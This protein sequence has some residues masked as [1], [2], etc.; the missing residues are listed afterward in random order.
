MFDSTAAL[1]LI[2]AYVFTP[3]SHWENSLNR[4][5]IAGN[6]FTYAAAFMPVL[7]LAAEAP[8][9][10][11]FQTFSYAAASLSRL[12]ALAGI[13]LYS[14][15]IILSSRN[16]VLDRAFGGLDSLYLVHHG[17]GRLAFALV[18]A[19]PTFL[20]LRRAESLTDFFLYFVPGGALGV[21]LGRLS[22][23]VFTIA[24]TVTVIGRLEYQRLLTVHRALGPAFLLGA[25]HAFMVGSNL[26]SQPFLQAYVGT[27]AVLAVLAYVNTTLLGNHLAPKRLY[28]VDRVDAS[29]EGLVHIDMSPAGDKLSYRSGQFIFPLFHQEGLRERHPFSL[30]SEESDEAL[31][32]MVRPLGDYTSKLRELRPGTRVSVEGPYGGFTYLKGGAS[33][34]WVAGGIGIT[35]FIGM[36]RSLALDLNPPRVDVYYSFR[37]EDDRH[38][39][40]LMRALLELIP[41]SR[42]YVHETRNTPRLTAS[43]ISHNSDL[44][45]ADIFLCGPASM[46]DDLSR[47]LR[48]AGVR[49]DR[50]HMERFKLL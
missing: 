29:T 7:I 42:L 21:N 10:L 22:I 47:Q 38:L 35:P 5:I 45:D 25:V 30:T 20:A 19:H 15:N 48:A 31:S 41:G 43:S 33:Q 17:K 40:E 9:A 36:A 34:V 44:E 13:G 39:S 4:R 27:L 37:E 6:A 1:I 46:L 8:W 23:W 32:L 26:S 14:V 16:S 11:S 24:I 28:V 18:L 12:C 50:V 3:R 2:P 49:K